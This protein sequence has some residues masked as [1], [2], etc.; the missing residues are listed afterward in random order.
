MLLERLPHR[1]RCEGVPVHDADLAML[2]ELGH[3]VGASSVDPLRLVQRREAKVLDARVVRFSHCL[4][5]H[6]ENRLPLRLHEVEV[7]GDRQAPGRTLGAT[8][9]V[10]LYTGRAEREAAENRPNNHEGLKR[11]HPPSHLV[12]VCGEVRRKPR[13]MDHGVQGMS[14]SEKDCFQFSRLL[15]EHLFMKCLCGGMH[16]A[17]HVIP[18]GAE[19]SIVVFVL[20][21]VQGVVG[22]GVDE[23]L[24]RASLET[25][26][27]D[28]KVAMANAIHGVEPYKIEWDE[29][30]REYANPSRQQKRE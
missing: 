21:V 3:D 6:L 27:H 25:S 24:Q 7:P 30:V 17:G 22:R 2:L 12:L 19:Q 20:G 29:P 26:R 15:R 13:Q 4:Q 10:S 8:E 23:V 1:G 16:G 18:D 5:N 11:D 28:L 14:V 9:L